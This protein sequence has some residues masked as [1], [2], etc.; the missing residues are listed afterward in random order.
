M[1]YELMEPA[2]QARFCVIWLHGLGADGHDFVDIVN[3]FDVSL[4]EI[5]FIFPHADIIPVTI[6]M[7]MQMR[8]WYDIKSLDANSLNRV[9]DVEGINS[10]IAKVNKLIDSQVNQGIA[11]ENIILAGFSQ[12][13]VIATYTAITSQ[14]KLGGIMALSTYLPAW[15]NFKGKITSINKGLP[16]LVCHGTDDQVLP[17][18]LGHDLS[19]KLKVSGFANEYKH[20]VGMQHSVCMEEI[21]DISNFIAKTF[22]I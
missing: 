14:R 22:K 5:R 18:V 21:K 10:S 13:G 16:I 2:K 17:E 20:Y 4:D 15:D 6:N 8:A 1:N 9:V 3:Y 7:G 11:S 12:G 19:D